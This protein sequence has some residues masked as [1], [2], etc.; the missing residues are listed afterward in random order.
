MTLRDLEVLI[1]LEILNGVSF[2]NASKMGAII[3]GTTYKVMDE[4]ITQ[5]L[6][7][8]S[9][10]FNVAQR[11]EPPAKDKQFEMLEHITA[12][13]DFILQQS[14][15]VNQKLKLLLEIMETMKQN[16]SAHNR[17]RVNKNL[18][19][20]DEL[21]T[22]I[23]KRETFTVFFNST[24]G[25]HINIYKRYIPIIVETQDPFKKAELIAEHLG[26]LLVRLKEFLPVLQESLRSALDQ[27]DI[28]SATI[29]GDANERL[30]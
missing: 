21:W 7:L 18:N 2:I 16:R 30:V 5:L 19:K 6:E 28:L 11:I 20:V 27:L 29:R 1:K 17:T 4:L 25:Q 14:K 9:E 8:P 13:L 23:A 24:R 15:I 26:N 12:K 22:W 10:D 3:E